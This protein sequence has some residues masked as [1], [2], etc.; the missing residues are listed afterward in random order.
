MAYGAQSVGAPL[1]PGFPNAIEGDIVAMNTDG[2]GRL[3]QAHNREY[4]P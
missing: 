1:Y 4:R 3:Q 2:Q